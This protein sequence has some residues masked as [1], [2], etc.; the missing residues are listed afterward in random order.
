[1]TLA[2]MVSSFGAFTVD[3]DACIYWMIDLKVFCN[4]SS[5]SQSFVVLVF[6]GSFFC[7]NTNLGF[8]LLISITNTMLIV[9]SSL[10]GRLCLGTSLVQLIYVG[11]QR[12]C[13]PLNCIWNNGRLKNFLNFDSP[14]SHD[15]HLFFSLLKEKIHSPKPIFCPLICC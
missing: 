12:S 9:A 2:S 14:I 10:H 8:W 11:S 3:F 13:A 4:Y 5:F 6:W 15:F 1:M 7:Y